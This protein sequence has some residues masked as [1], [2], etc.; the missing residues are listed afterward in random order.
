MESFRSQILVF[1][2]LVLA[3]SGDASA[4]DKGINIPQVSAS[5]AS[6]QG[7]GAGEQGA[8]IDE[9]SQIQGGAAAA[10]F[11]GSVINNAQFTEYGRA[12]AARQGTL[13]SALQQGGQVMPVPQKPSG[14]VA[15]G[16][17]QGQVVLLKADE[18]EE[19]KR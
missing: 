9:A 3:F 19:K 13:D 6:G 5:K 1:L 8:I 4:G 14:D 15:E 17:I 12:N 10:D 2:A 7:A 16:M 18:E 11:Q